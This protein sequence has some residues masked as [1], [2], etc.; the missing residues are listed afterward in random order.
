MSTDAL[1]TNQR[2]LRSLCFRDV[3]FYTNDKLRADGHQSGMQAGEFFTTS[4][5]KNVFS[6]SM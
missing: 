2:S 1:G 5:Q 4:K 3:V 6:I